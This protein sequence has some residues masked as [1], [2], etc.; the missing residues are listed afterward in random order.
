M[1]IPLNNLET[2][3]GMNKEEVKRG[4][5]RGANWAG[6]RDKRGEIAWRGAG[7]EDSRVEEE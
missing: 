3:E 5:R 4:E 6:E 1:V 2:R 7:N